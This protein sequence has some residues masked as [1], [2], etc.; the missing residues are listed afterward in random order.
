M[1]W[2]TGEDDNDIDYAFVDQNGVGYTQEELSERFYYRGKD[3][4][5]NPIFQVKP[6]YKTGTIERGVN[7]GLAI[8]AAILKLFGL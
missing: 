5:G 8:G 3:K 2:L 1:G 6:E 7:N 4:E